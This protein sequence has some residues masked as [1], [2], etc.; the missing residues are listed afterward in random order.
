MSK[1]IRKVVEKRRRKRIITEA[2]RQIKG[3]GIRVR[4]KR[5]RIASPLNPAS[6]SFIPSLLLP[7]VPCNTLHF[8]GNSFFLFYP[9][10]FLFAPNEK[11][12]ILCCQTE[13]FEYTQEQGRTSFSLYQISISYVLA[14]SLTSVVQEALVKG[15]KLRH[16]K[17]CH[18]YNY[19][20][21]SFE[22]LSGLQTSLSC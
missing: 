12:P 8:C 18:I 7:L 19:I 5:K 1:T 17:N 3:G 14:R 10:S 2:Q 6:F 13:P 16:D 22:Y 11:L 9:F 21:I 20:Y 15:F 4:C